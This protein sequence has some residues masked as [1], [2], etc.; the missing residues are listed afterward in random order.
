[1]SEKSKFLKTI[2]LLALCV[3]CAVNPITGKREFMLMTESQDLDIGKK[4]APELEKQMGGK[5]PDEALQNYVNTVGQKV[6]NVSH[7]RTYQRRS[8]TEAAEQ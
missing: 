4:Y 2:L 1:M 3:G 8:C 5:I 6:A 7:R